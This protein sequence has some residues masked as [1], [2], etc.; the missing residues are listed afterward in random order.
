MKNI[1][2]LDEDMDEFKDLDPQFKNIQPV[3]VR[4]EFIGKSMEKVFLPDAGGKLI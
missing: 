3:K 2:F 1:S 4:N